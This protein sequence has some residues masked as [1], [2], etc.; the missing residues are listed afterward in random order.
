MVTTR[1]VPNL[2]GAQTL[3]DRPPSRP[4][5]VAPAPRRV[6]LHPHSGKVADTAVLLANVMGTKRKTAITR[7]RSARKRASGKRERLKSRNATFFARRTSLGRFKEMN[8]R[9]RSLAADRRRKAKLRTKPDCSAG[10]RQLT[11]G[12]AP[13]VAVTSVRSLHRSPQDRRQHA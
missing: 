4:C 9:G 1:G 13:T 10:A 3:A 5:R 8:E 12:Y 6:L 7:K 2:S 11:R